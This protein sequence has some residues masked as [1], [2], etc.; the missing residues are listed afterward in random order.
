M[1]YRLGPWLAAPLGRCE[2]LRRGPS[3]MSSSHR[4][5]CHWRGWWDPGLYPLFSCFCILATGQVSLLGCT[6]PTMICCFATGPKQQVSQLSAVPICHDFPFIW[7][8]QMFVLVIESWLALTCTLHL[9]ICTVW[10]EVASAPWVWC[11]LSVLHHMVWL[12]HSIQW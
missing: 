5:R 9:P 11:G 10:F 7:L 6:Y 12:V 2:T 8:P 3:G 1:R 4:R